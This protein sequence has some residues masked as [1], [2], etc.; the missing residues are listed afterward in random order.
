MGKEE[1]GVGKMLNLL[2]SE[3]LWDTQLRKSRSHLN[4]RITLKPRREAGWEK[5]RK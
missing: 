3:A 5:G 1:I 4:T 2:D